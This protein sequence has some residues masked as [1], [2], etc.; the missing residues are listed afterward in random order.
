MTEYLIGNKG[1]FKTFA[2]VVP[3]LVDGDI[4][5][6]KKGHHPIEADDLKV[7]NLTLRG[8]YD[9]AY[10]NTM[11]NIIANKEDDTTPAFTIPKN[12]GIAVNSLSI[13]VAPKVRPFV[14]EEN[15]VFT[16][17]LSNLVWNHFKLTKL[18]DNIP[19][20]TTKTDE[21]VMSRV[22][23]TECIISAI[24]LVAREFNI[25]H[26][27]LGSPYGQP[28]YMS[29]FTNSSTHNFISNTDIA[30]VGE[31]YSLNVLGDVKVVDTN[32]KLTDAFPNLK[33]APL[34]INNLLFQK[35]DP[36]AVK[37]GNT[38]NKNADGLYK[39][40]LKSQKDTP[41]FYIENERVNTPL[42]V[43]AEPKGKG[44]R[45]AIPHDKGL[46]KNNGNI[47]IRGENNAQTTWPNVQESGIMVLANYK[48]GIP[49]K[50]EGG[51][52][53]I[54]ESAVNPPKGEELT[55]NLE[56]SP[57]ELKAP[58]L[59]E[60]FVTKLLW[61]PE[62]IQQDKFKQTPILNHLVETFD[63]FILEKSI[64]KYPILM[65]GSTNYAK[66][67]VELTQ[68]VETMNKKQVLKSDRVIQITSESFE[69]RNVV[70]YAT[71][72]K[73]RF[74]FT[75]VFEHANVIQNNPNK[76]GWITLI[77]RIQK[78]PASGPQTLL[79]F[80]DTP[81]NLD[82]FQQTVNLEDVHRYDVPE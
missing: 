40:V 17:Q 13:V 3:T 23:I 69:N 53:M 54:K 32:E 37:V 47:I 12:G 52:L 71:T 80:T 5:T 22:E 1:D 11:I 82:T 20:L 8:S 63:K 62:E 70:D 28:S 2:E 9:E 26:T 43:I 68:F 16:M 61:T 49:F 73:Q 15:S 48:G 4:V 27:A 39:K 60:D 50:F 77:K 56:E 24:D 25:E 59:T 33:N 45:Y 55:P 30:M 14:F 72:L 79:I 44:S 38:W 19:L 18:N 51:D 10:K 81:D 78:I 42:Y 66:T 6:F 31:M 29:G 58:E 75:W 35:F 21:T 7:N 74:G 57:F 36:K 41:Q 65:I 34:V 76:N 64:E 67:I 46:L